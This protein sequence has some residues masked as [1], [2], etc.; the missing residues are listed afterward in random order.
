[1]LDKD[2]TTSKCGQKINFG[3]VE[4]VV[5]LALE[6]RM[7]LL[8]DL[9]LN[10]TRQYPWHLISFSTEVNLMPALHAPVHVDMQDLALNDRLLA[11]AFLAPISIPNDLSFTLTL[12]AN[13]LKSLDHRT[14]LSHHGLHTSTVAAGAGLDGTLLTSTSIALRADDGFLQS[15]LRDLA[16]VDVFK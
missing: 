7:W 10:V 14:H 6:P 1:M 11:E 12:W 16:A 8:L 13:G 3:M 4:E 2:G 5:V 9:E 15:Q